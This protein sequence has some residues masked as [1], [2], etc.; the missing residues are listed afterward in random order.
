MH[1]SIITVWIGYIVGQVYSFVLFIILFADIIKNM[2]LC[3]RDFRDYMA[4]HGKTAKSI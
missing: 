2:E 1:Y 3:K 4:R